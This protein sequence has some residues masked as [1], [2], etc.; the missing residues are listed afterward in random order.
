MLKLIN[1]TPPKPKVTIYR[2]ATGKT[3]AISNG[4]SMPLSKVKPHYLKVVK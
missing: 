3:Y 4:R 1:G 2:D